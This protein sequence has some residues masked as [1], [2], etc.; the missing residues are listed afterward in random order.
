[1]T[2]AP[3]ITRTD[4]GRYLVGNVPASF[5]DADTAMAVYLDLAQRISRIERNHH[6]TDKKA[7]S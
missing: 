2:G 5:V 7:A 4:S 3:N 1:M 6:A